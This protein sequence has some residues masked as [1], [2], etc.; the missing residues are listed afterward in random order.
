MAKHTITVSDMDGGISIRV[1][2][3]GSLESTAAGR[4]VK[5]LTGIAGR[6]VAVVSALQGGE[7]PCSKCQA[8]RE[9]DAQPSPT[10]P[11]PTLH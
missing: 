6:V 11:K 1:E 5:T 7:C 3:D 4:V 2:G 9:A 8:R 10:E